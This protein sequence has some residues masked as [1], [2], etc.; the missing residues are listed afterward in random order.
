MGVC[1]SGPCC[2]EGV[3]M[4]WDWTGEGPELIIEHTF[5]NSWICIH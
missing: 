2:L 4:Y 5:D 1:C 3:S